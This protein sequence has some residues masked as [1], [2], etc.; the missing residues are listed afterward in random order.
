M[1]VDQIM[2]RN[3]RFCH[4]WDK[5]RDAAQMMWDA[6]CGCVPVIADD[7]S[8]QVV[9]ML[10]DRDIC[11]ATYLSVKEPQ[12]ISVE[13]VMSPLVRAVTAS[14]T[15]AEAETIMSEA[16]V[17]R[18]PVVNN[19]AKLVGILALA[20]LAREAQ[21]MRATEHAPITEDEIGDT[22][23]AISACGTGLELAPTA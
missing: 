17:R 13:E 18:L 20:D 21:R 5:L 7:G 10:T 6:D 19:E 8:H 22:L 2:T 14:A 11:M 12:E 9:G 3:V 23:S 1:Q 15:L 4:T 16:Q